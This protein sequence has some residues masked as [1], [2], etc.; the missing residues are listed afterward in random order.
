[1]EAHFISKTTLTTSKL[2]YPGEKPPKD[3]KSMIP[4]QS[5]QTVQHVKLDQ[6]VTVINTSIKVEEVSAIKGSMLA[7]LPSTGFALLD[8]VEEGVVE[9]G[10]LETRP[11]TGYAYLQEIN[12]E[13]ESTGKDTT[14]TPQPATKTKVSKASVSPTTPA[15]P[16]TDYEPELPES[17]IKEDP[18]SLKYSETK[19]EDTQ[20]SIPEETFYK[21][22][23]IRPQLQP[24]CQWPVGK[25]NTGANHSTWPSATFKYAMRLSGCV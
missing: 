12:E 14:K 15:S 2:T 22:G 9:K 24:S 4:Q 6:T 21:P 11:S 23:K 19:S 8:L 1:M 5:S 20:Q 10:R 16:H 17:E 18:M 7:S 3:S 25:L 13:A